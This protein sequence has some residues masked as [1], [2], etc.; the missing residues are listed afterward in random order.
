ML[1]ITIEGMIEG[2]TLA[3]PVITMTTTTSRADDGESFQHKNTRVPSQLRYDLRKRSK[4]KEQQ[5]SVLLLIH[6][7]EKSSIHEMNEEY[8]SKTIEESV[9]PRGLSFPPFSNYILI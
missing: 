8:L 7:F 1:P 6:K 9:D 4:S 2:T 3:H 5:N